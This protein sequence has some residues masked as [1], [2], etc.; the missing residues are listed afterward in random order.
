MTAPPGKPQVRHMATLTGGSWSLS[1]DGAFVYALHL[2]TGKL[3][4]LP[5]APPPIKKLPRPTHHGGNTA[6]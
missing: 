6:H 4:K 2:E 3:A 1:T 5:V